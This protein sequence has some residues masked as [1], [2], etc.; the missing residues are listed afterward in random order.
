M[1][2]AFEDLEG[3]VTRNSGK[4]CLLLRPCLVCLFDYLFIYFMIEEN[5]KHIFF[6][7]FFD[8]F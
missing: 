2:N 1:E 6:K 4:L 8:L 7:Y 3:S 5:Q